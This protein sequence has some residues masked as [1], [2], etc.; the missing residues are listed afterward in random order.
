MYQWYYYR[1]Q[2]YASLEEHID[3]NLPIL[4]FGSGFLKTM[5]KAEIKD[6]WMLRK[7]SP[8]ASKGLTN[9]MKRQ[10]AE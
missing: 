6:R 9:N 3:I 1:S 10:V 5:L 2:T 4:G 8:F 7:S